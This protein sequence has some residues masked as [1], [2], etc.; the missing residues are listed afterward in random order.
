MKQREG[1][2]V[3]HAIVIA[4]GILLIITLLVWNDSFA[5]EQS[6]DSIVAEDIS[7][8]RESQTLRLSF[9]SVFQMLSDKVDG[10]YVYISYEDLI[11]TPS[12]FCSAKGMA[13]PGY[14]STIVSSGGR[15]TDT[16]DG[17]TPTGMLTQADVNHATVFQNDASWTTS[18]SNPYSSTTSKTYGRFRVDSVHN[19]TPA[20]A[21]VLSETTSNDPNA[22]AITYTITD[23]EYTGE[24][25]DQNKYKGQGNT[26]LWAVEWDSD[27]LEPTRYVAR[28]GDRYYYVNADSYAPYTYV[29][30]AWWKVK[31]V[32]T[33]NKAGVKDTDLAY[34]AEAFEDYMERIAVTNN[35]QWQFNEDNTVKVDYT[36]YVSSDGTR[37]QLSS[38][39][40][41]ADVRFDASTN[42][43]IVGPFTLNY[44]RAG[45][46][47]G[48]REKVSFAGISNVTLVASNAAGEALYDEND[49]SILQLGKNYRFIYNH[50]HEDYI[51]NVEGRG[52]DKQKLDTVEDYPYPY[53]GEEF[54]LEI[55]Y[56]DEMTSLM[57][58][59]FDFQ[60]M[61]AGGRYEYLKGDY[62]ILT[63][64]PWY[65]YIPSDGGTQTDGSS[66]S[67]VEENINIAMDVSS[68]EGETVDTGTNV[69]GASERV[70][71]NEVINKS[72][73]ERTESGNDE[74]SINI[75]ND[76]EKD[77]ITITA[78]VK[79]KENHLG[80][81]VDDLSDGVQGFEVKTDLIYTNPEKI[82]YTIIKTDG[83]EMVEGGEAVNI[84]EEYIVPKDFSI[85]VE[86]LIIKARVT[87]T[88][89]TNNYM[90]VNATN[91]ALDDDNEG[92]LND[93]TTSYLGRVRTVEYKFDNDIAEGILVTDI[94]QSVGVQYDEDL[95]RYCKPGVV[96]ELSTILKTKLKDDSVTEIKEGKILWKVD[97]KNYGEEITSDEILY[98]P[99]AGIDKYTVVMEVYSDVEDKVVQSFEFY[100]DFPQMYISESTN[101]NIGAGRDTHDV[102]SVYGNDNTTKTYYL[103]NIYKSLRTSDGSLTGA[104]NKYLVVSDFSLGEV[105]S[106]GRV[107]YTAYPDAIPERQQDYN[108]IREFLYIDEMEHQVS[109]RVVCRLTNP[110]YEDYVFKKRVKS[111]LNVLDA[112]G[113]DVDDLLLLIDEGNIDKEDLEKVIYERLATGIGTSLYGLYNFYQDYQDYQE[114]EQFNDTRIDIQ[115][116]IN[117]FFNNKNYTAQE[118]DK[119][120]E[121]LVNKDEYKDYW[122]SDEGK[123]ISDILDLLLNERKDAEE[124][125]RIDVQLELNHFLEKG[126]TSGEL[127][128]FIKNLKNE[129]D[130]TQYF[131]SN[132][133]KE[134]TSKLNRILDKRREAEQIVE[135]YR[136][137]NKSD[138]EV[139]EYFDNLSDEGTV[140][141]DLS[142]E[143]SQIKDRNDSLREAG[144]YFVDIT[145]DTLRE[146]TVQ[147]LMQ[148]C[149]D[150]EAAGYNDYSNPTY[151]AAVNYTN[152]IKNNASNVKPSDK[153]STVIENQDTQKADLEKQ[154]SDIQGSIN[155]VDSQIEYSRNNINNI[156]QEIINQLRQ[157]IEQSNNEL[158]NIN[159]ELS[160]N[161]DAD[162][163]TELERRRDELLANIDNCNKT[164]S[165]LEMMININNQMIDAEQQQNVLED[166][167]EA[168]QNEQFGLID[169]QAKLKGNEKT[170]NKNRVN[171]LTEVINEKNKQINELEKNKAS[172]REDR[173]QLLDKVANSGV[174]EEERIQNLQV[175]YAELQIQEMNRDRYIDQSNDIENSLFA[176]NWSSSTSVSLANRGT[177]FSGLQDYDEGNFQY[178]LRLTNATTAPAQDQSHPIDIVVK[179][180]DAQNGRGEDVAGDGVHLQIIPDPIELTTSISGSVWIDQD[181][182]PK[183]PS[184]GTLGVYDSN[185]QPA[186]KNSVE[187]IVWKV[188][189][190]KNGNEIER[191]KA[192]GWDAEKNPIDFIDNKLY[193]DENGNYTIP[194]I[195]IPSKEGLDTSRYSVAY[196]VEF[197]YDG[198]TYEATEYFK[199]ANKDSIADKLEEFKLTAAETKGE[200]KD[201]TRFEKDSYIVENADER[202]AFDAYFTE[203]YGKD[204]INTENGNTTG[205]STGGIGGVYYSEEERSN[206]VSPTTLD[207]TSTEVGEGDNAKRQSDL[208]TTNSEGFVLDQYRFAA[209]T[210]TAGLVLPY[211]E[212]YHVKKEYYDNLDLVFLKMEFKPVDEYFDHINLGLLERYETD[213]SLLKDLYSAKVV[214]NEQQTNYTFNSL[215]TLTGEALSQQI[216][217]SYRQMTYKLDLYNSDYYYR[218]SV[219]ESVTDTI[220]KEVLNA[221]KDETE[222]RLFVTY[223]IAMYNESELTDVSINEFKDYYDKTFTLITQETKASIVDN[224]GNRSDQTVAYAPYY[225]KLK[226]GSAA[227]ENYFWNKDEDLAIANI[228]ERVSNNS[229]KVTGDLT[230]SNIDSG[231]ENYK[232]SVSTSLRAVNSDGTINN[233]MTL[234]PGEYFEVFVTYEVDYEGWEKATQEAAGTSNERPD[235]LG[236][237]TNIAEITN[238]S[239]AYTTES[240]ARHKTTSYQP[241]QISGKV[242]RD[243]AADNINMNN[244][245]KAKFFE[246]DTEYAPTLEIKLK[247]GTNRTLSGI[248]WEDSRNDNEN[249]N[250]IYDEGES[251][252]GGVDVTL[253]EKIKI[254]PGDLE[255]GAV[256]GLQN[257]ELLDYEFEY[258]WP[259][260]AFGDKVDFTAR[261][262]SSTDDSNKGQYTF[263]NFATGMYV[264]R[265]EYGN[266]DDT[267]KYNGQDYKNTSYQTGMTN[268]T[269]EIGT[270]N[271]PGQSTL[272]NEWHDLSNNDNAKALEQTRVSDARDY[273]P[274]RMQVMAY[275][276]TITNENAEVLAAY[277]NDASSEKVTEE[278][279]RLLEENKEELIENT[280]MVANTAKFNVEI[281]K[282][283]S[284]AY[285]T[286]ETTEGDNNGSTKHEYNIMN[287]DFGLVKRP[288]T[289]INIKKEISRLMLLK[290]DGQEI[291]LSV[292]CDENGDIIKTDGESSN[293]NK[294]TEIKKDVL[295]DGQGFKYVGIESSYLQGLT[296]SITYRIVVTNN[297]E[298]DY[299]GAALA[300]VKNMNKLYEFAAN[301]ESTDKN[302]NNLVSFNTGEGIVYGK[303]LG[304]NYYTGTVAQGD[305]SATY[306][307]NYSNDVSQDT[308]VKTTIDQLVDYVDNDISI[309]KDATTNIENQ[310]WVDSTEEDREFKFSDAS[311][312]ENEHSDENFVDDKDRAYIGENKNNIVLTTS[313]NMERTT[314]TYRRT[315]VNENKE[316]VMTQNENGE[317]IPNMITVEYEA[318]TT[319]GNE[320][321]HQISAYNPKL[322]VELEPG[323]STEDT[324]ITLSVQANE[325]SMNN[326]NYNNL[327][328]VVMY[329]N[330]AGRRDMEAIPGNANMIAKEQVAHMAGSNWVHPVELS[331]TDE[332]GAEIETSV[333]TER[334]AYA[335]RDT[336]TFSE[337]TGLSLEREN[338]NRIV[339]IILIALIVAAVAVIA[340]TVVIV[341]RKTKY[342]DKDLLNVNGKN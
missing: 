246:D 173:Q 260:G 221:I 209:R 289:R 270:S 59:D 155:D 318:Y 39:A 329:S 88:L 50:N 41:E 94:S 111:I 177:V 213:V 158:N 63:W 258:V 114:Q 303:Y 52:N 271:K 296:L 340:V 201:Y 309:N 43:Y 44:L 234:E 37:K 188:T 176:I 259:D 138:E 16:T 148:Y 228:D 191:E 242:D 9:P 292:E 224:Q 272:N 249:G 308:I 24:V 167:L 102:G 142:K 7:P 267:L 150:A 282:Q 327:A 42:K 273:E 18:T 264:V 134:I 26:E 277:V 218:S 163:R 127:D 181:E 20:E 91:I 184:T 80:E 17:G 14:A 171:E 225:R 143:I 287:V 103:Y 97:E 202:K 128:D 247:E 214:V 299:V 314:I 237:K 85:P 334:D 257:L 180:I 147:Q 255:S 243:S 285:K 168:L 70:F 187:I 58:L 240:V 328:E 244:L 288:E 312:K 265:F 342:D 208:V 186:A 116:E 266:N 337:P 27:S 315:E 5:A 162:R 293:V 146:L 236:L 100:V 253:V 169:E 108:D 196:D 72:I 165:D 212:Q 129:E 6:S 71:Q 36:N 62:L 149:N 248:V 32:G 241:E 300:E 8:V 233:D 274:R 106:N 161:I 124:A 222:L 193:I 298:T 145:I 183:D 47:Q 34:E 49:E 25:N 313:E 291:V 194:E 324:Y 239:S 283:D 154:Q 3:T 135:E 197:I 269:E 35:G 268:T 206:D 339:R 119:F 4:I 219:Y 73:E 56:L 126:Y 105:Y 178:Y 332:N 137:G 189:Y 144:A 336:V 117:N 195:Q 335:A 286:V 93:S 99:K 79:E 226:A 182:D 321:S 122:A 325:D 256:Q 156:I 211:E 15:S 115:D 83:T 64:T 295:G 306:G 23:Q 316:P 166:E 2:K 112:M 55:D 217:P 46:K 31:T 81:W 40:S 323:Q 131:N 210:S 198:Q 21:W 326:M 1:L 245:D 28:Q 82:T 307:F 261:T 338:I 227:S 92:F 113:V 118:L 185:E 301:Y 251:G 66:V 199:S 192:I 10:D 278:Y 19:A 330:T 311:Y 76:P 130:Y 136:N 86:K 263:S 331:D 121:D 29:Q 95:I 139:Q 235:L 107:T 67:R 262:K 78:S 279:R 250:G 204:D 60:Y 84:G 160:G 104:N 305:T 48:S 123:N 45:T 231:N 75:E 203:V 54:Y 101:D 90:R 320:D 322:T 252:I 170:Q 38:D 229:S 205:Q 133:G 110:N 51:P 310:S 30:H 238:Y 175:A 68:R 69:G 65:N 120:I 207:Y 281:E 164:I 230:F 215:G 297:S 341:V 302:E 152:I 254:N 290:N 125:L 98:E 275:S 87:Y 74:I 61:N 140:Y 153:V 89:T 190:D 11:N 333:Y 159:S 132:E 77:H 216:D 294:I 109:V 200:A 53:D 22:N 232:G 157:Q 174:I 223:R 317:I 96:G 284:I 319:A 179:N 151:Q 220:T 172:L 33:Q 13:L 57:T 276:R 12:L 141:D 280:A 304:L